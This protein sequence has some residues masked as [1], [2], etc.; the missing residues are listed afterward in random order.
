[1]GSD[2]ALRNPFESGSFRNVAIGCY[3]NGDGSD[4]RACVA[5]WLKSERALSEEFYRPDMHCTQATIRFVRAFNRTGVFNKPLYVIVPILGRFSS[6]SA[7]PK[8]VFMLEPY[9]E[10][11]QKCKLS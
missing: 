9:I 10:N 4:G 8:M 1:M 6:K 3:I 2:K 7:Y 5:K 11:Y